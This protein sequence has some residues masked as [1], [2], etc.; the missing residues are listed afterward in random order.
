MNHQSKACLNKMGLSS[1]KQFSN[2]LLTHLLSVSAFCIAA[3]SVAEDFGAKGVGVDALR[4][5]Y[6][7]LI[8]SELQAAKDAS[9]FEYLGTLGRICLLPQSLSEDNTDVSPPY[10]LNP[11]LA[12]G[13]ETWYAKPTQVF[14][15][16]YFVG[17]KIHSA[18]VLK[19]SEGLIVFDTIFPY[20]SEALVLGGLKAL[21]LDPK[22]IKYL[23]IS[24][25]HADHIGG[26]QMIQERFHPRVVM[27]DLDWKLVEEHPNR[28][29]SM[30]PKRDITATDGMQIKLGD[31]TVNIWLTPGHTPSTLS[32]TFSVKD[33]GRVVQVVYSGG[34]AFNFVNKTPVPGI[35]NFQT[36]IDSQ[37][38]IAQKAL[39]SGATVVI[40]NHSEFD[41]AVNKNKMLAGRGDEPHPYELGVSWVQRYF[42]VMQ[43]CAR[44]AQL[45]LESEQEKAQR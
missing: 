14:D 38:H 9:E 28:Y 25:A 23:L 45:A 18:W 21:G 19:T 11:K 37:K 35:K 34:T 32:Y 41:N 24:H 10:V 40:S 17:G 2:C 5:D 6:T 33:R 4:K 7:S 1:A 31:D 12:P 22:D 44:A 30:A 27:G 42:S 26:A 13:S 43:H 8:R 3:S 36:Y 20:N 15:N 16:F 29:K 39:E